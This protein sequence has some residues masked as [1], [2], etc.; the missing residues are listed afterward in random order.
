MSDDTEADGGCQQVDAVVAEL[1][2]RLIA[3]NHSEQWRKK[4]QRLRSAKISL[5]KDKSSQCAFD[6]R[7]QKELKLRK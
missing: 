6:N 5:G 2:R 7:E 3:T 4:N 1:S